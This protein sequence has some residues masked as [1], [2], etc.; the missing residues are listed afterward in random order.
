MMASIEN[1]REDF[2]FL[3]DWEERYRYIIELG[4]DLPDYPESARDEAH[5]VR[6]CV[7][8]VWLYTEVGD[9]PDPVI[10]FRGD[11]DAHIVR[12]LVAIMMALF[13]G[14]RASEILSIDAEETLRALGLDEH[15]TP[16]RAN[17]LRAMVRRIKDEATAALGAVA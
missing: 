16:Q 17:G 12:G 3:D 2:A 5:K 14:K 10:T 13:S 11:S 15:L 8:Q 6:G 7:S 1:I 4:G 9:G